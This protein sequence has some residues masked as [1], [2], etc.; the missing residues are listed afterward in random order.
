MTIPWKTTVI[1]IMTGILLSAMGGVP[2]LA[3]T[4]TDTTDL[5][6]DLPEL[7]VPAEEKINVNTATQTELE[8]LAGIG[9]VLAQRIIDHRPYKTIDDLLEVPG[10]GEVRLNAIRDRIAVNGEEK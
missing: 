4:K 3:E 6:L 9:P 8:R 5:D 10:I 7:I 1:G 2:A